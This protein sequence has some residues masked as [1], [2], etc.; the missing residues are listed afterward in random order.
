[1]WRSSVIWQTLTSSMTEQMCL[2]HW[3]MACGVPEIVTALSVESG[4]MS[5][6]TWTW[7]PVV[8]TLPYGRKKT[9]KKQ[10]LFRAKNPTLSPF[11]KCCFK[12]P[13]ITQN[14]FWHAESSCK[15]NGNAC[16]N[17]LRGAHKYC[18]F[19]ERM[20]AVSAGHSRHNHL[21][22]F[23]SSRENPH[24]HLLQEKINKISLTGVFDTCCFTT[25]K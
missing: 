15:P 2:T 12:Q 14:I 13:Q 21:D 22:Y 20:H 4:N 8:L 1:M 17:I 7:A 9:K 23:S 10:R 24:K 5:P 19:R 16:S 6:A 25:P 18:P 11:L 3:V